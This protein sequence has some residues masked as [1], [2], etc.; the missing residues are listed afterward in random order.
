MEADVFGQTFFERI[1]LVVY[2]LINLWKGRKESYDLWKMKV[3]KILI[4]LCEQEF[5]RCHFM[6]LLNEISHL[7]LYSHNLF[8]NNQNI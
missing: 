6:K 5:S 1:A 8:S 3:Y 2:L 7:L 4:T